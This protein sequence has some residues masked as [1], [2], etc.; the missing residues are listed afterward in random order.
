MGGFLDISLE[1]LRRSDVQLSDRLA[2]LGIRGPF[3]GPLKPLEH[4]G[5]MVPDALRGPSI[6]P[7]CMFYSPPFAVFSRFIY[8]LDIFIH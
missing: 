1:I 7:L 6:E 3:K 4:H 2:F 5:S 8:L